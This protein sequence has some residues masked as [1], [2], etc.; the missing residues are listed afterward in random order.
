MLKELRE[1][2]REGWDWAILHRV[3]GHLKGD[4]MEVWVGR[5]YSSLG[6]GGQISRLRETVP[7]SFSLYLLSPVC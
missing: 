6:Q 2:R 4:T 7:D 1:E 3:R 5:S